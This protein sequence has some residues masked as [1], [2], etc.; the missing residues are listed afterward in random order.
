M[1]YLLLNTKFVPKTRFSR[2]GESQF[3]SLN[4]KGL[5]AQ[6]K[7]DVLSWEINSRLSNWYVEWLC[8]FFLLFFLTILS[9]FGLTFRFSF[10]LSERVLHTHTYTVYRWFFP[11]PTVLYLITKV[12][13]RTCVHSCAE[14]DRPK[15]I[16]FSLKDNRR[17]WLRAILV[18][19][20]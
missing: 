3:G 16:G 13:S 17:I 18:I 10:F 12:S 20:I 15:V 5:S 4:R 1:S 19:A 6:K 2:L 9:S 14:H 8:H 11:S 7:N